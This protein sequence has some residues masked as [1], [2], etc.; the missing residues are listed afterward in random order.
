M[1][2]FPL[3]LFT[4]HLPRFLCFPSIMICSEQGYLM[5]NH[6]FL[7]TKFSQISRTQ[8]IVY[9]LFNLFP[10]FFLSFFP[11]PLLC[12]TARRR[13]SSS[14]SQAQPISP[15]LTAKLLGNRVAVSPI[16]TV[17]PRRRKFHK[18]ITLTI[19]LPQAAG[20]GMIN[21]YSTGSPPSSLRL[22]CSITGKFQLRAG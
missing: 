4:L 11:R 20:K 21:D 19:P 12:K 10:R 18:A 2:L 3:N 1:H 5:L 6:F 17:E 7:G 13:P 22:L 9:F 16:V 8:I 14:S 15:E